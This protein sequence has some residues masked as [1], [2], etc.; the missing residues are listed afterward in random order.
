MHIVYIAFLFTYINIVYNNYSEETVENIFPY[1]MMLFAGII[2][3]A[4]YDFYQLYQDPLDYF[5]DFWN[6]I[7]Q[8][9]IWAA[10]ANVV[11]QN[12]H[13]P[14]SLPCK[15]MMTLDV[16]ISLA[17]TFFFLRI[18]DSFSPI[19]T[20]LTNVISDLL[21]FLRM[22]SLLIV[23]F[24]LLLGIL[25]VGNNQIEGKFKNYFG[26]DAEE[27]YGEMPGEEYL[28]VGF[29]IANILAT[30]RMSMGDFDFEA[31]V[32]LDDAEGKMF[33]VA[34]LL[35]VVVTMIIFLNFIIAEATASYENVD[36]KLYQY[37][38][39]EQAALIQEAEEMGPE[40]LKNHMRNPKYLIVR[41]ME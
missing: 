40:K 12:T 35:I 29:F 9:Y 41:E 8:I 20:M 18:F 10:V 31:A 28:S 7:D 11:I 25:G 15:I 2:Y 6:W 5:T 16:L 36:T 14:L 27:I 21:V 1:T 4:C 30:L 24:S 19:V 38:K 39:K 13:G 37:I 17:K 22:Y 23:L 33:W 3:P 32:L 26:E 34:W